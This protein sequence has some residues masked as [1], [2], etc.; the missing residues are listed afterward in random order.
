MGVLM[1]YVQAGK[2]IPMLDAPCSDECSGS[3]T[4]CEGGELYSCIAGAEGCME[5]DGGTA[6][7]SG[8]CD[9]S[10]VA[11]SCT[12]S[13]HL[14][15]HDEDVYWFDSCDGLGTLAEDCGEDEL[16]G[17]TFCQSGHIYRQLLDRTCA[18]A[19]CTELTT[20]QKVTDCGTAGCSGS[21]CCASHDSSK[22][23][24]GELYWYSSC[25]VR[26]DVKDDCDDAGC[27]SNQC[28]TSN[29]TSKCYDDDLYYYSS[30]NVRQDKDEDCGTAGCESNE[31][32]DSEDYRACS[33]GDVY[34]YSS[35]DVKQSKYDECGSNVTGTPYCSGNIV[36]RNDIIRGCSGSSCTQTTD[37]VTVEDCGTKKVCS[38]G[39]CEC[40]ASTPWSNNTL[41]ISDVWNGKKLTWSAPSPNWVQTYYIARAQGSTTPPPGWSIGSTSG[42]NFTDTTGISGQCY[43][44]IVYAYN[45][46]GQNKNTSSIEHTCW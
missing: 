22:C 11:C 27:T 5:W 43:N 13:H 33:G 30:C 32:C 15:C 42:T 2:Y 12:Y 34:W 35:C 19:A 7:V 31:C 36:K 17:P 37:V 16:T 46:C 29:H 41:S 6:C 1:A 14:D 26:Q 28:C 10:G 18:S 23:Y 25:N 44:Y 20:N 24:S 45:A 40:P 9:T 3:E 38:D 8:E 4:K 21:T 39:E